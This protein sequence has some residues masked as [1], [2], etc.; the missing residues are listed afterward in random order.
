M[1]VCN[2]AKSVEPGL[3][4]TLFDADPLVQG[5]LLRR[6]SRSRHKTPG[7]QVVNGQQADLP[8]APLASVGSS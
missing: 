1:G 8:K 3:Q 4:R 2:S 6:S 5:T 7:V